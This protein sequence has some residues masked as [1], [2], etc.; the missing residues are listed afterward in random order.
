MKYLKPLPF[1]W[2]LLSSCLLAAHPK[3]AF[4]RNP[5]EAT[6]T[7]S[8]RSL[9]D[10][11]EPSAQKISMKENNGNMDTI[12]TFKS[13]N[14]FGERV[15]K[16]IQQKDAGAWIALYPS[17]EEYK[18]LLQLMLTSKVD[19]LTQE[20]IDQMMAHREKE[21]VTVFTEEFMTYRDQAI[22][23]KIDWN[24]AVLEKFDFIAAPAEKVPVKYLTGEIRFK[25]GDRHFA[26]KGLEAVE[27][28][29]GYR[30]QAVKGIGS[31]TTGE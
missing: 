3:A 1:S 8:S 7:S 16:A 14:Q 4:I 20:M 28:F 31:L 24:E 27:M 19:G 18:A 22:S 29:Y 30:L 13:Q 9:T 10:F 23:L 21:A 5:M 25:C 6:H 15:F 26:L 12:A 2:L 11:T 17:N